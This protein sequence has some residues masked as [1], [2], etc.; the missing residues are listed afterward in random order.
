MISEREVFNSHERSLLLFPSKKDEDSIINTTEP[1]I[2]APSSFS[3]TYD[4]D[5]YSES[6]SVGY[7]CQGLYYDTTSLKMIRQIVTYNSNTNLQ[8]IFLRTILTLLLSFSILF[9]CYYYFN[10]QSVFNPLSKIIGSN[11]RNNT[12]FS[13]INTSYYKYDD[14]SSKMTSSTTTTKISS[15]TNQSSSSCNNTRKNFPCN[16]LWGVATS[17]YQIEGGIINRGLNI[18]DIFV[19]KSNTIVDHTSGQITDD[20]YHLWKQDI[21]LMSMYFVKKLFIFGFDCLVFYLFLL[22]LKIST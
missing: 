11:E 4:S 21:A 5:N 13:K 22:L 15:D 19:Q 7:R 20:H 10:C 1:T 2:K 8:K 14:T 17:S 18:W 3:T 9:S 16:F 6:N 12:L